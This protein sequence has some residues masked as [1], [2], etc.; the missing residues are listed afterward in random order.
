MQSGYARSTDRCL[1]IHAEL[2][3][4]MFCTIAA[5]CAN[6]TVCSY[7]HAAPAPGPY[8]PVM[9]HCDA[10][11]RTISGDQRPCIFQL[12]ATNI[13]L[14]IARRLP[15][16]TASLCDKSRPSV[17]VSYLAALSSVNFRALLG[18]LFPNSCSLAT[19]YLLLTLA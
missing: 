1:Q 6:V 4:S 18:S 14:Q 15:T 19:S 12:A 11:M 7:I 3:N 13:C 5:G 10:R 8:I 2:H 9:M 16:N 17:R